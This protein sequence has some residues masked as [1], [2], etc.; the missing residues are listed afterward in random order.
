[1]NIIKKC[2]QG[3]YIPPEYLSNNLALM[4]FIPTRIWLYSNDYCRHEI[5]TSRFNFLDAD[6]I[7][8][9]QLMIIFYR[10]FCYCRYLANVFLLL[11]NI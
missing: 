3:I 5:D 11:K 6:A 7:Y 2:P 1:L 10:L 9:M 8:F 4:G